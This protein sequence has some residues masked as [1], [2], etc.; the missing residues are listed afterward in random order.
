MQLMIPVSITTDRYHTVDKSQMHFLLEVFSTTLQFRAFTLGQIC[1]YRIFVPVQPW[2]KWFEEGNWSMNTGQPVVPSFLRG[3]LVFS[4]NHPQN[5]TRITP[6]LQHWSQASPQ[7]LS[8][9]SEHYIRW[10]V[11]VNVSA[12]PHAAPAQPKQHEA[13][14]D[15]THWK[16]LICSTESSLHPRGKFIISIPAGAL[17]PLPLLP[18]PPP[19]ARPLLTN[20]INRGSIR[21]FLHAS[22]QK[23]KVRWA[24]KA[25]CGEVRAECCSY[26]TLGGWTGCGIYVTGCLETLAFLSVTE[27]VKAMAS[28]PR[29]AHSCTYTA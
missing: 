6:L 22:Q 15:E 12:Q 2:Q 20:S 18:L 8:L 16:W 1:K 17:T 11:L 5:K 27:L 25:H 13:G 29:D 4:D 9:S 10:C 7:P 28:S 3:F 24:P 21:A 19:N 23:V 26:Q 14:A